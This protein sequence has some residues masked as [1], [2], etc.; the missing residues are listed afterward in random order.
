MLLFNQG[1]TARDIAAQLDCNLKWIGRFNRHGVAGL[2]EV[3]RKGRPRVYGPENVGAVIQAVLTPPQKLRLPF[4]SWTLDRLVSYLSE[5]KGVSMGRTRIA[6][7]LSA[8]GL[9]WRKLEGWFGE[10]VDT[11]LAK[12]RGPSSAST[13]ALQPTG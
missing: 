1:H 4:A 5:E 7:V 6:E 9:R 13:H 12:K 2:G 11:E 3:L 10:R 8:E